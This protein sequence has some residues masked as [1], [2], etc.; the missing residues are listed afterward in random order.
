MSLIQARASAN[1]F[2]S[3][4]CAVT[5]TWTEPSRD[6]ERDLL[7][8]FFFFF[9]DESDAVL[10][11]SEPPPSLPSGSLPPPPPPPPLQ[12]IRGGGLSER[13]EPREDGGLLVGTLTEHV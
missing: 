7:F 12:G 13:E 11:E 2:E 6:R 8:S 5:V 9:S 3:T 10:E 4:G 1:A